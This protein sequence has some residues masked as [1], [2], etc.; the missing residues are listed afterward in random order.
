MALLVLGE[1]LL[2]AVILLVYHLEHLLVYELGG[3]VGVGPL[4]LVFLVVVVAYVGQAVAHAGVGYH[5]V[6][7]LG[8]AL[9][10]VH[11]SRGDVAR[12]EFL[13]GAS[14]QQ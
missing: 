10:V 13:G 1:Y 8:G 14:S 7:A 3:A 11:G 12:E 9:Q 6:G 2:G 5:A 4:E